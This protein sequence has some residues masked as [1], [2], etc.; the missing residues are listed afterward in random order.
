MA[1][2]VDPTG[3]APADLQ[4]WRALLLPL[5]ASRPTAA[6]K[7]Q[8]VSP[9]TSHHS[10]HS[11]LVASPCGN[12]RHK[13]QRPTS[14][15]HDNLPRHPLLATRRPPR[16]SPNRS[17]AAPRACLRLVLRSTTLARAHNGEHTAEMGP[18]KPHQRGHPNRKGQHA[19][20]PARCLS[21][22]AKQL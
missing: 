4:S 21:E 5:R 2:P 8:A 1:G 12:N 22:R 13:P 14:Q 19:E 18:H 6:S 7:A 11:L 17:V 9:F 20:R 3:V 10:P 15:P 16:P